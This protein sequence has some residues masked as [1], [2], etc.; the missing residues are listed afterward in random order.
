VGVGASLVGRGLRGPPCS[1]CWQVGPQPELV[2]LLSLSEP[3][4]P[5]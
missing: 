5:R 2:L 1:K 4:Q 3:F